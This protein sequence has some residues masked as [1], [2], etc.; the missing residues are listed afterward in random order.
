MT[1]LA[2]SLAPPTVSL[3]PSPASLP[4]SPASLPSSSSLVRLTSNHDIRT[5][6][7]QLATRFVLMMASPPR[8]PPGPPPCPPSYTPNSFP[9]LTGGDCDLVL[10]CN[11]DEV[12]AFLLTCVLLLYSL[13]NL[14][15]RII[16]LPL[17]WLI[18]QILLLLLISFWSSF[19]SWFPS[20]NAPPCPPYPPSTSLSTPDLPSGPPT[21]HASYPMILFS[22]F[23]LL[24]SWRLAPLLVLQVTF[25]AVEDKEEESAVKS[26]I[27]Q[28]FGLPLDQEEQGQENFHLASLKCSCNPDSH[29]PSTCRPWGGGPASVG[30]E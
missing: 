28:I 2:A 19:C 4:P 9:R 11:G 7:C 26:W 20:L 14:L 23:N 18:P 25:G 13:P 27:C 12:T 30:P 10:L 5:L 15:L 22:H 16:L 3:P 8:V 24:G 6:A 29:N 1:V 21:H 17:V